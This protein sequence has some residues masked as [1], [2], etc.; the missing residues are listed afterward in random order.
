MKISTSCKFYLSKF[1]IAVI[2]QL[3]FV[4]LTFSQN[5]LFSKK[6]NFDSSY[7]II[8]V[9]DFFDKEMTNINFTFQI[10]N[11]DSL[12]K[13]QKEVFYGSEFK[14]NYED[15]KN[16]KYTY[17]EFGVIINIV[18]DKKSVSS[19]RYL[20]ITKLITFADYLDSIGGT[21]KFDLNSI[22]KISEKKPLA[23]KAKAIVFKSKSEKE[24]FIIN[25]LKNNQL[26]FYKDVTGSKEGFFEIVLKADK[27]FHTQT[28]FTI[29]EKELDKL[30]IKNS[31]YL[32]A[33]HPKADDLNI[34][35]YHIY[36][37]ENVYNKFKLKGYKK[38]KW[39][40][41]EIKILSY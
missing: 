32:L 7:Q 9:C 15:F 27:S 26:L 16:H 22:S 38:S 13:A 11:P 31:E 41:T 30:S 37:S 36:A 35:T 17:E 20:P 39:N 3:F 25:N 23:Y 5:N 2:L 8:A 14:S 4:I 6:Y 18:K 33:Y 40:A 12:K 21:F 19:F 29:I 24:N 1:I 28:G 34:Y 10:K